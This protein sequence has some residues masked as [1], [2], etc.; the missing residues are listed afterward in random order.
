MLVSVKPFSSKPFLSSDFSGTRE[1]IAKKLKIANA[2]AFFIAQGMSPNAFTNALYEE[3]K[4]MWQFVPHYDKQTFYYQYFQNTDYHFNEFF[5]IIIKSFKT[6]TPP[7]RG[8]NWRREIEYLVGQWV[9]QYE[10]EI[11]IRFQAEKN[12]RARGI[13]NGT[14]LRENLVFA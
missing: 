5:E 7:Y 12:K 1:E 3:L 9:Q 11:K 6:R 14:R 2:L 8:E 10:R 13:K 4:A